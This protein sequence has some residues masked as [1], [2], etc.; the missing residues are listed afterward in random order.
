[1]SRLRLLAPAGY[2]G[3]EKPRLRLNGI[4][5]T[6]SGEYSRVHELAKEHVHETP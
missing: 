1:M 6:A 3:F 2:T 5:G 4:P